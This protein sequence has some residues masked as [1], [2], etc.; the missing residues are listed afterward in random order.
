[1]DYKMMKDLVSIINSENEPNVTK[2]NGTA[3]IINNVAYVRLDGSEIY[4]PVTTAVEVGDGDR[5][6]VEIKE[7]KATILSNITSPSVNTRSFNNLKEEVD[8]NG[9]LIRMMDSSITALNASV[10]IINGTLNVHDSAIQSVNDAVRM[11]GNAILLIDNDITSMNSTIRTINSELVSQDAKINLNTSSINA[12]SSDISIVKSNINMLNSD[13]TAINNTIVLQGN[14]IQLINNNIRVI[15]ND[16]TA[17]NNQIGLQNNKININT[18]DI[19]ILNS[20]FVIQDGVLTGLSE[21]VVNSLKT[22]YLN[23]AY[24]DIDFA[25]IDIGAI[26][27]LFTESGIINDLVVQQGAITGELV[28]V[29][30]KG[31]LI[32]ANTLKADKI[33][34][35]GSDGLYYKLNIDGIDNI[36]TSEAG[37]FALTTSKP[38]DWD[39]N[40]KDYYVISNSNYTHVTGA[41]APTWATNT[42][43][44]LNSDHES[45]LD[46]STIIAH[47]VTADRIQ[48]TDLVAFGATIGGFVIGNASIYSIGKSSINSNTNGIYLGSDGQIYIGDQNNHMKYYKDGNNNWILDIRASSIYMGSSSKTV[49]Q[50]ISDINNDI[51]SI[52]DDITDINKDLAS[53]EMIVGT[54]VQATN[55]WTGVAPFDTLTDGTEI[56]YW[57]PF[58]GNSSNATLNLTLSNGQTTG[59]KNV[60]YSG[61]TRVTNQYK[62]GNPLRM[63][64]RSNVVIGTSTCTGWW[65]D[66]NYNT[67]DYDRTRYNSAMK[68]DQTYCQSGRL[69]ASNEKDLYSVLIPGYKFKKDSVIA[70]TGSAINPVT[71]GTNNYIMYSAVN[72]VNTLTYDWKIGNQEIPSTA[73]GYVGNK[74]TGTNTTGQIFSGSGIS[75][76]VIGDVYINTTSTDANKYNMYL[77]TLGGNA[78]TAK[79]AYKEDLQVLSGERWY[80]GSNAPSTTSGYSEGDYY[81]NTT[82][83]HYYRLLSVV[84]ESST[85]LQWTDLGV[86]IEIYKTLYLRCRLEDDMFVVDEIPFT[87]NTAT[88]YDNIYYIALGSTYSLTA[89]SLSPDHM[90]YKSV[91]IGTD[92]EGNDI[93]EFKSSSQ[94]SIDTQNQM[95][96]KLDVVTYTSEIKE[97]GD[98]IALRVTSD[99]YS[100]GI[101]SV[102]QDMNNALGVEGSADYDQSIRGT[103]DHVNSNFIF[104][105]NGLTISKSNSAMKLA[106]QNS[107]IDFILSGNPDIIKAKMTSNS[108]ILEELSSFQLGNFAFVVRSNGS[109][110]FKK[111]K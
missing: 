15:G 13:I 94:I 26:A 74:I 24:A 53:K 34:V 11:Q 48:V 84:S 63:V 95:S 31:D 76:A 72:F 61:T 78:S 96:S 100:K 111:V 40:Y 101:N 12:M 99:T 29:T 36:S 39:T 25:N 19:T 22:D 75:S 16:I 62:A 73:K 97:L 86:L 20:G 88:E 77:C 65:C 54:Q 69:I 59:A 14:D 33:V 1:M 66:A 93:I 85:I 57:L 104:D 17:M 23:A 55:I 67:N 5:V 60:Y 42:Y 79:W 30:L 43:Y 47:S 8:E 90:I 82:N 4:T 46:G 102:R 70:Y 56:L 71:T 28:G 45:G 6:S 9:N 51:S 68:T 107:E 10:S 83:G 18:A 21:I 89:F 41:S 108:F 81:Y 32:E 35:R 38:S 80:S 44:K 106:L 2:I 7:H 3:K 105:I 27:T 37:K 58:D 103:I 110:D 50:E 52:D 92:D 91:I 64:Y 49:E 98:Q 109:I 87:T